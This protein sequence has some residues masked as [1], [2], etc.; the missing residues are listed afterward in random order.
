MEKKVRA[1]LNARGLVPV[2]WRLLLSEDA[3]VER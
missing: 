3:A 2:G 1:R